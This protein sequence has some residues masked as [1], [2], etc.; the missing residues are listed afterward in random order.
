[1][2]MHDLV[3]LRTYMLHRD[4]AMNALERLHKNNRAVVF[5]QITARDEELFALSPATKC[6]YYGSDIECSFDENSTS[7]LHDNVLT[8][9]YIPPFLSPA[10][11]GRIRV[12]PGDKNARY[13][14]Y[15]T[16]CKICQ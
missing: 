9:V 14:N 13:S 1:M 8:L 7:R 12:L 10:P 11:R 2:L 16:L 5:L 15:S 3:L 6:L 4:L